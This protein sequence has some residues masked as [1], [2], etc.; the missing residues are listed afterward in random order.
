MDSL[1]AMAGIDQPVSSISHLVGAVL[2]LAL[3]PFLLRSALRHGCFWFNLVFA[4]SAV[5]LLAISGVYHIFSPTGTAG[6]VMVRIDVAAVFILIAGT[7]T[8]I[9]GCLFTR[10]K[11]WGILIPLWAVA[12]TGLTLRTIFFD[13]IPRAAGTGI[14]LLLGWF[15]AVSTY[16]L[17]KYYGARAGVPVVLGGICYT[18]GA[19]IDVKT[20]WQLIPWVWG[21]HET[22]HFFVLAGLGCHW[23]FIWKIADGEYDSPRATLRHTQSS[24]LRSK[25]NCEKQG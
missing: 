16:L 7:F 10:W 3:T 22:F 21:P 2:F 11:R 20:S 13:N 24:D 5:A 4:L 23:A 12:I 8:P 1:Y 18:I 9:H 25:E 14:F 6:R 15:G 17:W 19:I